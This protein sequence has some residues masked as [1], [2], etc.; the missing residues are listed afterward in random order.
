MR[1]EVA[2]EGA[3]VGEVEVG[4]N[5]FQAAFRGAHGELQLQYDILV[6]DVLRWKSGFAA[7]DDAQI[8]ARDVHALSIVVHLVTLMKL[9]LEQFHEA[10]EQ[11]VG[12]LRALV[13]LVGARI[14]KQIVVEPEKERLQLQCHDAVGERVVFHGEVEPEDSEHAAYHLAYQ[15]RVAAA[16]VGLQRVVH[17]VLHVQTRRA[18][19]VAAVL[20]GVC[21][22]VVAHRF[23]FYDVA[24]E[25]A[26]HTLAV[27]FPFVEV[28]AY[29]CRARVAVDYRAVVDGVSLGAERA[30]VDAYERCLFHVAKLV[31]VSQIVKF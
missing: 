12:A 26:E 5:L 9:L 10:V 16:A 2:C 28:D 21:R 3:L 8:L 11:F 17:G 7:H 19:R 1:A 18:Q 14:G 13:A 20:Y 25:E 24:G 23:P 15:R 4:G 22:E 29:G 31:I 27:Q 6:D 30:A